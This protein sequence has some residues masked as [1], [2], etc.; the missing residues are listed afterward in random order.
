M[1]VLSKMKNGGSVV[2]SRGIFDVEKA[3]E[4]YSSSRPLTY[5][6]FAK[7]SSPSLAS[8][9]APKDA[10]VPSFVVAEKFAVSSLIG[11]CSNA[12]IDFSVVEGS[13]G[14]DVICG[15]SFRW[16]KNFLVHS[17]ALTF[18]A[19]SQRIV[20]PAFQVCVPSKQVESV[21]VPSIDNRNLTL[22]KWNE[23][24]GRIKRLLD[25]LTNV[26]QMIL[27]WE[28]C[29]AGVEVCHR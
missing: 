14:I 22:R 26:F 9:T 19:V 18:A 10:F 3:T 5:P 29:S 21:V 11:F 12:K 1:G 2:G 28:Y 27:L 13:R 24:D 25:F 17:N 20:N 8:S 16:L 15:I 23:S 6:S 7:G 4:F